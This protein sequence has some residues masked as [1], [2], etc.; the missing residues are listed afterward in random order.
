MY[1]GEEMFICGLDDSTSFRQ[2]GLDYGL[3][4]DSKP[5]RSGGLLELTSCACW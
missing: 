2:G 1:P 4:S 5:A 3:C